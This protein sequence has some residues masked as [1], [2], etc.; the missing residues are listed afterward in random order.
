[1]ASWDPYTAIYGHLGPWIRVPGSWY[2]LQVPGSRYGLQVPPWYLQGTPPGTSL[3]PPGYTSWYLQGTP[4]GY[5]SWYL[6]G[7]CI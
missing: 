3:V 4:P 7:T 1:M 5:T 6:P 2:G